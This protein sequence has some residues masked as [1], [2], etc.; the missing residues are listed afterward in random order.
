MGKSKCSGWLLIWVFGT[1]EIFRL[2]QRV[3]QADSF[4][5]VEIRYQASFLL[6]GMVL[7]PDGN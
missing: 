1:S 3:A 2:L 7:Y 4:I 5:S 6:E